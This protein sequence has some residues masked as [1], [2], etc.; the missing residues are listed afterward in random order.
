MASGVWLP[1]DAV[2]AVSSDEDQLTLKGSTA[3]ASMPSTPMPLPSQ[4]K[5]LSAIRKSVL[6]DTELVM[7]AP[8]GIC[9]ESTLS[10]QVV[11]ALLVTATVL[12]GA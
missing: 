4:N 10:N 5:L 9:A 12:C 7:M 11:P 8:Y 3:V 2:F 1:D 6:G